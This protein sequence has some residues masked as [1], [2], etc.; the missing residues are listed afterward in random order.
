[1]SLDCIR[2]ARAVKTRV[3]GLK[4]VQELESKDYHTGRSPV[5]RR[6]TGVVYSKIAR[7]AR[8][9]F[10]LYVIGRAS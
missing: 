10:V 2:D 8:V 5:G 7:V 4:S 1:M 3:S 9:V 6:P